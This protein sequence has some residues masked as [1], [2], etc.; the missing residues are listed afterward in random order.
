MEQSNN[1]AASNFEERRR[2]Y[3]GRDPGSEIRIDMLG[4]T[5]CPGVGPG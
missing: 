3:N 5:D 2:D 4:S 1:C